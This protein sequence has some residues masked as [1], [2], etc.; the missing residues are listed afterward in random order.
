MK[1]SAGTRTALVVVIIILALN[2]AAPLG[3]GEDLKSCKEGFE[4]CC[5]VAAVV[6][7]LY[8]IFCLQGYAFC[9]QFIER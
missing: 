5:R 4:A 7:P 1:L 3:R 2:L 8:Y 9:R 6:G